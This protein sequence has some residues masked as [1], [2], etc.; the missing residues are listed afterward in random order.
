MRPSGLWRLYRRRLR[1]RLV[2]ELLAVLGIA[3]G[4]ALV[5][6]AIVAATSLTGSIQQ[7]TAWSMQSSASTAS[8]VP[9]RCW[10]RVRVS[11]A[12]EGTRPSRWWAATRASPDSAG[13]SCATSQPHSSPVSGR[14]RCRLEWP[15]S[16]GSLST[17]R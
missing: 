8:S 17:A 10:R 2:Q 15:T 3:G 11:S 14:W 4:V 5:F 13:R 1:A 6:A 9:R 12:R 16:S 7:L